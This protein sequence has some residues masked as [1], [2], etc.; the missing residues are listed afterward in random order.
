MGPTF[1]RHTVADEMN[2]RMASIVIV[3]ALL[4]CSH[5]M[6]FTETSVWWVPILTY[7]SNDDYEMTIRLLAEKGIYPIFIGGR[8]TRV[9]VPFERYQE[10][11]DLLRTARF[12][13][14]K[15]LHTIVGGPRPGAP[16]ERQ[17]PGQDYWGNIGT[18]RK[19]EVEESTLI[20]ILNEAGCEAGIVTYGTRPDVATIFVPT[21]QAAVARKTLASSPFAQKIRLNY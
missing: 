11:S 1:G 13:G 16:L 14:K 15:W 6:E 7:E 4:G 21:V 17:D 3:L 10:A 2:G 9:W 19:A 8:G 18:F 12:T 20:K 5:E